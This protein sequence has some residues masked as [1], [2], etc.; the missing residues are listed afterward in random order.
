MAYSQYSQPQQPQPPA[1]M[2]QPLPTM[3]GM[4]PTGGVT[5]PWMQPQQPARQ[6][7]APPG[8]LPTNT[9]QQALQGVQEAYQ[10][11]T[12]MPGDMGFLNSLLSQSSQPASASDP[13]LAPAMAAGRVADQRNIDRQRSALAEQLGGAGL[14]S[15]GGMNTRLGGI[16]Q[17]VGEQAALRESGMV[18]DES[19]ARRN[20][21]LQALGLDQGRYQG[22]NNLGIRLAELEAQMNRDALGAFL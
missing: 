20:A 19:N 8:A 6:P 16:Q 4:Q 9:R 2:R 13:I 21:L 15:S 7:Q 5:N 1:P 14:G 22:D 3:G 10:Q 11:P 17:Q 18:M 12:R